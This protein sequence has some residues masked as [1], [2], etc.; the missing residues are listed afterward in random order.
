MKKFEY[1]NNK[2]K[3]FKASATIYNFSEV[4]A[5]LKRVSRILN[6]LGQ[7]RLKLKNKLLGERM[8][9]LNFELQDTQWPKTYIDHDRQIVR[10]IVVDDEQNFYF[11]K[12]IKRR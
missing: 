11:V 4:M 5:I 12:S 8:P 9:E 2:N 3:N 1:Q 7:L 10:A 6:C